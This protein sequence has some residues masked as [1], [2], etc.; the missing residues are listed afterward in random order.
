M[1][2]S[3]CPHRRLAAA[4]AGLHYTCLVLGGVSQRIDVRLGQVDASCQHPLNQLHGCEAGREEASRGAKLLHGASAAGLPH[5]CRNQGVRS[6]IPAQPT[7]QVDSNAMALSDTRSRL[8]ILPARKRRQAAH[9]KATRQRD[10]AWQA[11]QL[12]WSR[13]AAPAQQHQQTGAY[14]GPTGR[15]LAADST[16]SFRM[17]LLNQVQREEVSSPPEMIAAD[18][19]SASYPSRL[20]CCCIASYSRSRFSSFSVLES[21]KPLQG[22]QACWSGQTECTGQPPCFSSSSLIKPAKSL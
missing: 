12:S 17:P 11:T 6:I 1:S 18:S 19:T 22:E 21:A 2:D 14:R 5:S 7:L 13:E 4:S 15:W 9:V 16:S 10:F 8:S 3:F 20:P